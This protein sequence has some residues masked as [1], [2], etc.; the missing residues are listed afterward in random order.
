MI[1]TQENL[2]I[3]FYYGKYT[4]KMYFLIIYWY[5]VLKLVFKVWKKET[6]ISKRYNWL[7]E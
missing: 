5:S 6:F 7:S 1:Q 3:E 4:K 2:K